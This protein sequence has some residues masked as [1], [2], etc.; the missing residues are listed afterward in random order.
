MGKTRASK[1]AASGL[2]D[3]AVPVCASSTSPPLKKAARDAT[4]DVAARAARPMAAGP[5]ADGAARSIEIHIPSST[6]YVRVVRLAV[7][8]VASRMPFSY[9]DVEDIKLAVSEACN[10]A[11][12]H[13]TDVVSATPADNG[14]ELPDDSV[15]SNSGAPAPAVLVVLTPW[16]DRLEITVADEGRVPP[17]GIASQA[18]HA[19]PAAGDSVE[20]LREGGMGLF[21]M[22]ALMDRVEHH[23][24]ADSN[25]VVRLV[26]YVP[27]SPER[28]TPGRVPA[29]PSP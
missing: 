23:T 29:R 1:N 20:R 14:E 21:L 2:V 6:E 16:A 18:P 10:N 9:D 4:P 3:E 12:L 7:L 22:E 15:A 27:G 8:G 26:K 5:M 28:R 24:G 25:T 11:I 13:A 17:P 19:M